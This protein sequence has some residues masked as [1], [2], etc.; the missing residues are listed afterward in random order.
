MPQVLPRDADAMRRDESFRQYAKAVKAGKALTVN[1]LRAFLLKRT[2]RIC[3]KLYLR[4]GQQILSGF[5][6]GT[7][8]KK[9]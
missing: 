6:E 2:K 8:L 9:L 7:R 1:F 3:I 5:K 4:I